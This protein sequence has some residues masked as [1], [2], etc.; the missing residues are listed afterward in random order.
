MGMKVSVS[1][2]VSLLTG[3]FGGGFTVPPGRVVAMAT[4]RIAAYDAVRTEDEP[5]QCSVL[6]QCLDGVFRTGGRESAG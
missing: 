2:F 3:F 5:L 1:F 4:P 6:A